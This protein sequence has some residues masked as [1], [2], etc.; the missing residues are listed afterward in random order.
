MGT[1]GPLP[2]LGD[3]SQATR[4]PSVPFPP[5][6]AA[7]R[8]HGD[9]WPHGDPRSPSPPAGRLSGHTGTLGPLPPLGDGS[10][11]TRGPSVPF[12]PWGTALRPHGDPR[13]PPPPEGRLS[14]HTGTLG[15]L[16]PLGDGSQA[17]RGPSVPFPP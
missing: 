10:Q 6:G 2:P 4:G 13:S 7:L 11:A 16:P 9:P 14:G 1:L 3:G 17:T 5:W 15:P 12:P 8:P